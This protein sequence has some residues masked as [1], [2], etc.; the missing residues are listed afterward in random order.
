[1]RILDMKR[2][3]V[4]FFVL[5][6]L[7][8]AGFFIPG[9]SAETTQAAAP[10]PSA[11]GIPA[12][13]SITRQ[14][15]VKDEVKILRA[16]RAKKMPYLDKAIIRSEITPQKVAEKQ[17]F[18]SSSRARD[19]N[20]LIQ[21]AVE[22]YTPARAARERISLSK[23]RILAA[24]RALFPQATME[25]Q[26]KGGK[27]SGDKYNA[28]SYRFNFRQAIFHGGILWNTLLQEKA[29]LEAA[30]K[31]YTSVLEDLVK[32]VI[33]AYIEY[34]RALQ[35]VR[36]QQS[37]IQSMRQYAQ[38]SKKKF[39]EGIIS[40]IEHLNTQS[41]FSQME[42]DNETSKQ[43]LE[44]AKLDLQRYLDLGTEDHLEIVPLYH[45]NELI[46]SQKSEGGDGKEPGITKDDYSKD[47]NGKALPALGDLVDLAY[48]HRA[49]LQVESA[50]LE[51]A[52]LQERIRWGEVMPKGDLILEFGR[53][54][55]AFNTDTTNPSYRPELRVGF[56]FNW[57]IGGNKVNY[58]YDND[59]RAPSISQFLSGTGS[60]TRSSK[61]SV[62]LFDGL[63]EFAAIKEAEVARLDEITQLE[64]TEKE[65]VHDVK[66]SFFDYQ[67]ARI[68]V[69]S[70]LQRVAYRR[71]LAGLNKHKLEKNE[72]QISEYLQSEIDALQEVGNLQKALAD[73][74][75]AKAKLNNAIGIRNY[76]SLEES[77]GTGSP[78]AAPAGK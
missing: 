46:A 9:V 61:I 71:R 7:I 57:N 60:R 75:T 33:T 31:E 45:V 18:V 15:P 49:S 30:Q 22:L 51:A 2:N 27:L 14:L 21:R 65:V 23:R 26:D 11:D 35:V 76:F 38:L 72:I 17:K 28:G 77:H 39:T 5:G 12:S 6:I 67:K 66:Q 54:A 58:T 32:E 63:S 24:V 70:T 29:N 53:L 4:C 74:Y 47:D 50:K 44:L 36:D 42:Y 16:Q 64:K 59:D 19:L 34:S 68:R 41:L 1:M 43:E 20:D 56:E 52:R 13:A 78:A 73:Y 48:Q 25:I 8:S 10:Q 37:A 69:K 40:E 55:E 3:A 62:G